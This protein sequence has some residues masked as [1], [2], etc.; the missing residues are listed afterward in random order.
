MPYDPTLPANSSLILSA[1]LRAQ[2]AGLKTLID[3]RA[4][5]V[6]DISGLGVSAS[7]VYDPGQMQTI[8]DKLDEVIDGLKRA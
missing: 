3:A 1:E 5:R 6:D 8:A 7:P 2:F 4:H